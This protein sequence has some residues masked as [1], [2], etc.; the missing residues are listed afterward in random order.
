MARR[1]SPSVS[2]TSVRCQARVASKCS[3]KEPIQRQSRSNPRA[4]S[5]LP[6]AALFPPIS[7]RLRFSVN[8]QGG[9]FGVPQQF[10]CLQ[11]LLRFAGGLPR[12]VIPELTE[13]RQKRS[14]SRGIYS[15]YAMRAPLRR[16]TLS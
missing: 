7:E 6:D 2:L 8:I 12:V 15:R 4:L 3:R 11:E 9:H 14:H 16:L 5:R 10:H 13:L 1:N